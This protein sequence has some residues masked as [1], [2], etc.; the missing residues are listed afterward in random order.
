MRKHENTIPDELRKLVSQILVDENSRPSLDTI[1]SH[2]F[3]KLG[4][5]PE[6]LDSNATTSIPKWTIKPPSPAT[7]KRGYTEGWYKQ[8][9]A[10]GV[11]EY[12]P[13]RFFSVVGDS[14]SS[15]I[16]QE[17]EREAEAGKMPIVPIPD[18][19]IYIPFVSNESNGNTGGLE[20]SEDR[21]LSASSSHRIECSVNTK[22][23][24]PDHVEPPPRKQRGAEL[25]D[26]APSIR[27]RARQRGSSYAETV[28]TARRPAALRSKAALEEICVPAAGSVAAKPFSRLRPRT[29]LQPVMENLEAEP[30]PILIN[31]RPGRP[32]RT[33]S[34]RHASRTTSQKNTTQ[35]EAGTSEAVKSI[36]I[37]SRNTEPVE[38]G[39]SETVQSTRTTSCTATRLEAVRLA[40]LVTLHEPTPQ[41]TTQLPIF[42]LPSPSTKVAAPRS[43]K[44]TD[45]DGSIMNL[46]TDPATILARAEE[47]R[48]NIIT[49]LASGY[50]NSSAL[51]NWNPPTDHVPFVSKWVDYSKKYGIGYV[52]ADGSVGVIINHTDDKPL[53]HTVVNHGCKYL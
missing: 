19:A 41:I 31:R 16:Y 28:L 6:T 22:Y 14:T 52:L 21:E 39:L 49:A 11:G 7:I 15:S 27:A 45:P 40:T 35:A 18:G 20:N 38:S 2:P 26:P 32:S 4:H 37:T 30:K 24:I 5:L 1:V 25:P 10:S 46:Y 33:I 48:N 17:C 44:S 34:T 3:F 47:L 50:D 23:N 42:V 13:G 8:C 9:E 53:T 29:N 51:R 12:A 43:K 36:R